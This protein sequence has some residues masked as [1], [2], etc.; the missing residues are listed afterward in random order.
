VITLSEFK[1]L[2]LRVGEIVSAER[3]ERTARLMKVEVELGQERR[4]LVAGVAQQY[5]PD[6]LLG[7]KVI[8]VANLE[9]ATIR[10]VT[11]QGMMLGANCHNGQEIALLTVSRDVPIGTPVE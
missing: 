2:D 1:R 3:I 9:P 7:M 8:V 6:Q 11:S 5:E 10:G 4:T